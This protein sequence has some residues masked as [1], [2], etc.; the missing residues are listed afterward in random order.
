MSVLCP[1]E[2]SVYVILLITI[3]FV[4]SV[5]GFCNQLWPI[6]TA[7]FSQIA[8]NFNPFHDHCHC[9][10]LVLS[11]LNLLL[12]LTGPGR[13][14][15]NNIQPLFEP[16]YFTQ[17]LQKKMCTSPGIPITIHPPPHNF[18]SYGYSSPEPSLTISPSD[19]DTT[20]QSLRSGP[21]LTC[22][23]TR[24]GWPPYFCARRDKS[25]KLVPKHWYAIAHF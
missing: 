13:A 7:Y 3:E 20:Q 8:N 22:T 15:K 21:V 2:F 24:P 19:M 25:E 1:F 9:W 18:T 12:Y 11:Q 6:F 23:L 5:K 16:S 4:S 17:I 14:A 10:C